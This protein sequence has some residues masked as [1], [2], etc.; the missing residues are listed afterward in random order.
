MAFD[1]ALDRPLGDNLQHRGL[2]IADLL[3][4]VDGPPGGLEGLGPMGGA[5]RDDHGVL[6]LRGLGVLDDALDAQG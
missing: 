2:R 6:P 1:D 3:E 4:R 5:H